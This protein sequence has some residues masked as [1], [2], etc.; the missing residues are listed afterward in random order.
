M[1][2]RSCL[3]SGWDIRLILSSTSS[4]FRSFVHVIS[5]CGLAAGRQVRVTGSPSSKTWS[6]SLM[7]NTGAKSEG[8][9]INCCFFDTLSSLWTDEARSVC[10]GVLSFLLLVK[11]HLSHR[12][13]LSLS[14]AF[15]EWML[16]VDSTDSLDAVAP[17]WF[18]S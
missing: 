1:I 10:E 16:E 6:F 18:A 12:D 15:S 5:G 7:W 2:I 3:P 13:R 14:E 4:R 17:V 11:P 8:E 9:R